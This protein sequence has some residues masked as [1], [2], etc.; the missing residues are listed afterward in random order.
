MTNN[1]LVGWCV[2]LFVCL[3]VFNAT[4]NNISA[5]SWRS[6]L[7]VEETGGPE[8]DQV[9]D[10]L[11]H[12]V[13]CTSPWSRF[14]LTTLVMIGTDC[15]GSCK[16]NYHTITATTAPKHPS[17]GWTQRHIYPRWFWLVNKINENQWKLAETIY[18]PF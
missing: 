1:S 10:K 2:C 5:M 6:V 4:F 15:I 8:E 14:E 7:L 3:M 11:Y 16:S 12:K 18:T 9:T 17:N 13:L